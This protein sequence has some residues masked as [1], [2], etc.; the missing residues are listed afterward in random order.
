MGREPPVVTVHHQ[1]LRRSPQGRVN[2]VPSQ[3]ASKDSCIHVDL[4]LLDGD[5]LLGRKEMLIGATQQIGTFSLDR[6]SSN[7]GDEAAI[8]Q[9]GNTLCEI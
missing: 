2:P 8:V 9:N 1:R 3:R 5:T 6:G 4:T 7:L